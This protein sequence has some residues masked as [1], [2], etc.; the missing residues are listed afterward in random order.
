MDLWGPMR[1]KSRGDKRYVFVLV[2]DYI[3]FTWTIFLAF[4]ENAFEAFCTLV[5]KLDKKLDKQLDTARSD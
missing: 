3:R 5:R 2:D 1:V 4:K